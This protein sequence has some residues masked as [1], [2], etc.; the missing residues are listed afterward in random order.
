MTLIAESRIA[1]AAGALLAAGAILS[2]ATACG[3]DV[4]GHPVRQASDASALD[5]GNYP[6][7]PRVVPH[8]KTLKQARTREAQRLADFVALPSEADP[9]YTDDDIGL[10][11]HLVLNQKGMGKLVINDTF[12]DVAKDLVA[13]WQTAMATK[14]DP[15]GQT[16][17]LHMAVLEF[18]SA[19]IAADVGPTLEHDDF[20]YNV[21]NVA[22]GLPNHPDGKAHWRPA[23][24]SIGSWT[25]HDRY[26]VFIKLVDDTTA[27]DLPALV[28][29]TEHM[30][31]T[32]LPLLDKFTPTPSDQIMNID[33]DPD[34]LLGRT[35]PTNPDFP[36]RADPDGV[37]TGRGATSGMQSGDLD[38]LKTGDLDLIAFGDGGVFRS[39]T[40]K[41]ALALWQDDQP[42]THLTSTQR[43]D[44]PPKGLNARIECYSDLTEQGAT[45]M[46]LCVMQV[47]RYLVQTAAKNV[48]DL[49]QKTAAQYILLTAA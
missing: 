2:A 24:S 22:V 32:E 12:D 25:V 7:K 48:Q 6:I 11:Q 3:A 18:P 1:R 4:S 9:A 16:K 39:R 42:S 30:I 34:G 28:S 29:Q 15:N 26:V 47:D 33:M 45:I 40:A 41:G 44:D 8:A 23:I 5:V 36:L 43:M 38:F 20:T 35:L 37:Y 46:N 31:D 49:Y 19:A 13:G 27:P 21:D 14:S 17:Q 10:S